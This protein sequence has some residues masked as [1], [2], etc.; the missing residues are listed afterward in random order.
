MRTMSTWFWHKN[1]VWQLMF[2]D[3]LKVLL[4]VYIDDVVVK[5]SGFDAHLADLHVAFERMKRCGLKMN[6]LKCTFGVMTGKLL[7]FVVHEQG[8][9]IDLKK[10]ESIKKVEEPTCKR[11]VQK[12]LGKINYMQRFISN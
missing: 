9:E 6:P 7:G 1:R 11:D 12:L 4:E 3:L 5:S 10:I 2:H 8:V